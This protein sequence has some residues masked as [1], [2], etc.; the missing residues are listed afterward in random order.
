MKRW[1]ALAGL[2]LLTLHS[3]AQ[4]DTLT[5]TPAPAAAEPLPWQP[6]TAATSY[7]RYSPIKDSVVHALRVDLQ[8][9]GVQVQLTPQAERGRTLPHM[10]ST[11]G[12][13]ASVNASYFNKTFD[14]RGFT[15]SNG[16]AWSGITET[17]KSP[18]I[19]CDSQPRCVIQLH[20]P[21]ELQP[22]WT[23]VAAGIPWLVDEGRTRTPEDDATCANHCAKTH[24][25]LAVGLDAS[26]RWLY[27]VATEGRRPPVLGLTLTELSQVMLQ[28]G[29]R[30]AVNLDGGGS[31]T[32]VIQG[33]QVVARPLNE[34]ELR[35][36]ANALVI[37]ER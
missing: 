7:L 11:A 4:T 27:I 9:P 30:N 20:E 29:A 5:A 18:L 2:L 35:K 15:V 19:A 10:A 17:Q 13:V 16:E 31:T 3:Q 24:P 12:A 23:T 6:V 21:F 32:M 22:G 33:E 1:I 34:P 28:L 8:A 25:R 36:V 14:V 37:R 26:G